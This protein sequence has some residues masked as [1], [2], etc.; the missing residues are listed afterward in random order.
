MWQARIIN[1]P[2]GE[3]YEVDWTIYFGNEIIKAYSKQLKDILDR[4][5][6]YESPYIDKDQLEIP[7]LD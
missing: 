2:A 6:F 7:F 5:W 3:A 1:W 4:D